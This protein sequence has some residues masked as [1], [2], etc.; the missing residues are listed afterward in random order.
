[1]AVQNLWYVTCHGNKNNNMRFSEYLLIIMLNKS[2]KINVN[3]FNNP[4]HKHK[5]WKIR[6]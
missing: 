6:G 1:M 2:Y 5:K 3:E 4:L